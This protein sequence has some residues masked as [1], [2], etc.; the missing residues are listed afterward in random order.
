GKK[1]PVVV[2]IHGG[3]WFSG[4]RNG[5]QDMLMKFSD[6][7]YFAANIDYRLSN[8]VRFPAQIE[9]SKCAVRFL[10]AKS[11]EL[12]INAEKIACFGA[13]AGGHLAALLGTSNGVKELEGNGGWSGFSSSVQAVIDY[14]GPT[15]FNKMADAKSFGL[16]L[17]FE[18]LFGTPLAG[19]KELMKIASP[20]TYVNKNTPPFMIVHGLTDSTVPVAQSE[21]LA[22]LLKKNGVE[23]IYMPIKGGHG[24]PYFFSPEIMAAMKGFLK[25]NI[26]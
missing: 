16:E 12:N 23:V 21:L 18:N 9:D 20:V 15:D 4:S 13:S 24:G 17:A 1:I 22:N 6:M 11:E 10:R 25:K 7:G 8:V 5:G 3:G 2:M 26:E 19:K 14:Y